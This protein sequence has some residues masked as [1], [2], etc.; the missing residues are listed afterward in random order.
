M[1]LELGGEVSRAKLGLVHGD[2][3]GGSVDKF[4]FVAIDGGGVFG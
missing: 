4:G 1:V 2:N 3:A